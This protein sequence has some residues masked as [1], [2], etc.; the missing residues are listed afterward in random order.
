MKI[1]VLFFFLFLSCIGISRSQDFAVH[2]SEWYFGTRN[3]SAPLWAGDPYNH[4][5]SIGDTVMLGKTAHIVARQSVTYNSLTGLID[6]LPTSFEF[7]YQKGDTVY[8]YDAQSNAFLKMLTFNVKKG[9]SVSIETGMRNRAGI[10]SVRQ[11]LVQGILLRKY[12]AKTSRGFSFVYMDKVGSLEGFTPYIGPGMILEHSET[13]RCFT[14]ATLAIKFTGKACDEII[15]A[16]EKKRINDLVKIFPNPTNDVV[17]ISGMSGFRQVE[18]Y[19]FWGDKILSSFHPVFSLELF[20]KGA[21]LVKI[22]DK[23]NSYSAKVMKY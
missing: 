3:P 23:E 10:D 18:V 22:Y 7:V 17:Y 19:D 20:P 2:G 6:S 8:S 9:D 11:E 13:I 5:R 16:T 1:S 21:Y 14:D 15:T 4:Y 12:F